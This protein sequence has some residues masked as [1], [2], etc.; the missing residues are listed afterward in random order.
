MSSLIESLEKIATRATSLA[1]DVKTLME[2][3][4]YIQEVADQVRA[5]NQELRAANTR[6]ATEL[7][8]TKVRIKQYEGVPEE[9]QAEN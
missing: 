7:F 3:K 8:E 5:E 4:E 2:Y 6:L 9:I 1:E